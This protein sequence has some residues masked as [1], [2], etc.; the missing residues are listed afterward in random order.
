MGL[1]DK[2][3]RLIVKTQSSAFLGG[4]TSR[5]YLQRFDENGDCTGYYRD[6]NA[7]Y[8]AVFEK[9]FR[10]DIWMIEK[11]NQNIAS[12]LQNDGLIDASNYSFKGD[13]PEEER[14][15]RLVNGVYSYN[16]KPGTREEPK[17]YVQEDL[18]VIELEN[19][20]KKANPGEKAGLLD[21]ATEQ[22]ANLFTFSAK[23][24]ANT[25]A[26]STGG[27]WQRIQSTNTDHKMEVALRQDM[28]PNELLNKVATG[29]LNRTCN[30]QTLRYALVNVISRDNE[31]K[32]QVTSETASNA[33][34]AIEVAVERITPNYAN[35]TDIVHLPRENPF[36]IGMHIADPVYRQSEE[37]I[38]EFI[39]KIF[40]QPLQ[41]MGGTLPEK[42]PPDIQLPNPSDNFISHQE[43]RSYIQELAKSN[44]AEKS[45]PPYSKLREQ[46]SYRLLGE[47]GKVGVWENHLNI[48]LMRD[49]K[50]IV[51]NFTVNDFSLGQFGD[52]LDS[53]SGLPVHHVLGM[54]K[55]AYDK[56]YET[57]KLQAIKNLLSEKFKDL[58]EYYVRK[59]LSNNY[60]RSQEFLDSIDSSKKLSNEETFSKYSGGVTPEE[61]FKEHMDIYE[62]KLQ[63]DNSTSYI[64]S[65]LPGNDIVAKLNGAEG[66]SDAFVTV[67]NTSV[68]EDKP[69]EP[70]THD[71]NLPDASKSENVAS[72]PSSQG[73]KPV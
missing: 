50:R 34:E 65:P 5:N 44:A 60:D 47:E 73:V 18:Y 22:F 66:L 58:N 30:A 62:E 41:D 12:V 55:D 51:S 27:N 42:S 45:F 19:L 6:R 1:L 43:I 21:C 63:D 9:P 11:L 59:R 39:S 8:S 31:Y 37:G 38:S 57:F 71:N 3:R 16:S 56:T 29:F 68:T 15:N 33:L 46:I 35:N 7:V 61:F 10:D 24:T 23:S 13:E 72:V 48:T 4:T 53:W 69:V 28:D 49:S 36:F 54:E 52:H 32:K 40:T 14:I 20:L 17:S 26:I 25:M 64:D 70:E 67:N 2:V